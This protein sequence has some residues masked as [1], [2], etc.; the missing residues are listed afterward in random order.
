MYFQPN[1]R[2][3]KGKNTQFWDI[4]SPAHPEVSANIESHSIPNKSHLLIIECSLVSQ[5]S[6]QNKQ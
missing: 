6:I 1:L 3:S 5:N 2:W 4:N